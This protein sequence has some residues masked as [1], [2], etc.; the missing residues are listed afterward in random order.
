[1]EYYVVVQ[2]DVTEEYLFNDME[3]VDFIINE[4]S[5]LHNI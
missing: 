5:K 4:K 2:K 3:N 1:M